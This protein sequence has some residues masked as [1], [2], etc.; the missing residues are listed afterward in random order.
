MR[1]E[2][3]KVIH[4]QIIELVPIT[5]LWLHLYTWYDNYNVTLCRL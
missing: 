3:S 5:L 4:T 2:M 1:Y